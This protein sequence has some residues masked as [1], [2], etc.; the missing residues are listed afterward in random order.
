MWE[1]RCHREPQAGASG[2]SEAG[3]SPQ[4]SL[5]IL[6][7]PSNPSLKGTPRLRAAVEELRAA[8]RT[9]DLIELV[10]QPNDV[11]LRELAACDV[12][13]DQL[14]SDSPMAGFAAEAA[15]FGKP[16]IVGSFDW[17]EIEREVGASAP[18]TYRCHPDDLVSAIALLADDVNLRLRLGEAAHRFV[19]HRWRP[20]QVA[21]RYLR[22]I[23]GD[24]PPDWMRDPRDLRYVAGWGLDVARVAATVR[25]VID[26]EGVAALQV[27]D[28]PLLEQRLVELARA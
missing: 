18:P 3:T 26:D 12:V 21:Q 2:V 4:G 7:A 15:A 28:K 27:T 9:I 11:V 13:F 10:G 6:H 25:R 5:R 14:Y 23:A 19:E 8:G 16:T 24:V 22:I 1:F 17:P 20:E